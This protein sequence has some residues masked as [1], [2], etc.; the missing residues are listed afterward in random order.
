MRRLLTDLLV[1]GRWRMLRRLRSLIA[2]EAA[3]AM[4]IWA[5]AGGVTSRTSAILTA[6]DAPTIDADVFVT[7]WAPVGSSL[8]PAVVADELD[9]LLELPGVE[10][11]VQFDWAF[12]TTRLRVAAPASAGTRGGEREVW[13]L[14]V[15]GRARPEARL[16]DDL[17]N[18][19]G[20]IITPGLAEDL[21]GAVGAAV[22]ARVVDVGQAA[23]VEVLAAIDLPPEWLGISGGRPLV[24]MNGPP[25]GAAEATY[26]LTVAAD[27]SDAA[28]AAALDGFAA[29]RRDRVFHHVPKRDDWQ[30]SARHLRLFEAFLSVISAGVALMLVI[31]VY[32]MSAYV[33][34]ARWRDLAVVRALGW[35]ARQ[36]LVRQVLDIC[37]WVA[38]GG[39]IGIL[40]AWL[41][42]SGM[43]AE[44]SH[45]DLPFWGPVG[46]VLV[47]QQAVAVVAGLASARRVTTVSPALAASEV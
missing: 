35:S 9:G 43:A 28:M 5:N 27:V 8:D 26:A 29:A 42:H 11:V 45:V 24:L 7:R 41:W 4:T 32:G 47:F 30:R 1:A 34:A 22:G 17:A 33:V 13:V 18:Q 16:G 31:S 25:W 21:F 3:I 37:L 23:E 6:F 12:A 2:L 10:A 20:L 39:V 15:S 14:R 46:V 38:V 40:P 44:L 36:L 19:A